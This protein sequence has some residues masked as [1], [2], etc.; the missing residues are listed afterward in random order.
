MQRKEKNTSQGLR[1]SRVSGCR[2]ALGE[3]PSPASVIDEYN[4][5]QTMGTINLVAVYDP[6]MVISA[7]SQLHAIH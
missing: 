7:I 3:G 2:P 1:E 5:L 4:T 6:Y